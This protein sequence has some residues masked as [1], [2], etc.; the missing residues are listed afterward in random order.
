MR[1]SSIFCG[2]KDNRQ[3]SEGKRVMGESIGKS[4]SKVR[5][6]EAGQRG[7]SHSGVSKRK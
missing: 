1:I 2:G 6:R 3:I 5:K 7:S 4:P